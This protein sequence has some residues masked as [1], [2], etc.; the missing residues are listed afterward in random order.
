MK[1]ARLVGFVSGILSILCLAFLY[2]QRSYLYFI[3]PQPVFA[4]NATFNGIK[5]ID[6]DNTAYFLDPAA[7]GSNYSLIVNNSVGI[8]TTSPGQKLEVTGNVALTYGAARSFYVTQENADANGYNLSIKAGDAGSMVGGYQSGGDLILDGGWKHPS[9]SYGD[10]LLA[11]VNAGNV[12]IGT[13]GPGYPLEVAGTGLVSKFGDT[14]GVIATGG[15]G[16]GKANSFLGG[17][18]STT[19]SGQNI[20][21]NGA[22]WINPDAAAGKT[23]MFLQQAGDLYFYTGATTIGTG[24]VIILN[25][26]NV[27]IGT[28]SPLQLLEISGSNSTAYVPTSFSPSGASTQAKLNNIDTTNNNRAGIIFATQ[29][30]SAALISSAGISSIFTSHTAGAVSADLAFQTRNAGTGQESMRITSAGYVGIG[31]TAP[32]ATLAVAGNFSTTPVAL[33]PSANVAINC[34]LSNVFTL[35]P[36]QAEA[37][38]ATG[39]VAG[40]Y[41][42]LIILTSGTS[43]YTLTFSTGIK[44][45]TTT[46][47]TGTASGKYFLIHYVAN[48]TLLIEL[49][50]T[51]AL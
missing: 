28:T 51:A 16:A 2:T 31:T 30:T 13:T 42:D 10:V 33:T 38:T 45:G 20:Y 49:S 26:G 6:V 43:S 29:D 41:V 8:G 21:Y 11:T 12:G 35:T 17:Y 4:T 9:G 37:I 27:G 5:F 36:A 34:A 7:S 48:A 18:A 39:M 47:A 46:L 50:R 22:T 14:T 44:T 32:G 25:N 1:P 3:F 40:Q 24:K 23:S 15:I 19:Y